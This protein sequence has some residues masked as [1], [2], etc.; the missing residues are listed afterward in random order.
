[1]QRFAT[2]YNRDFPDKRKQVFLLC[3]TTLLPHGHKDTPMAHLFIK[4]SP[5]FLLIV[6][7]FVATLAV[8]VNLH[9]TL[10]GD[11]EEASGQEMAS[12]A[13][14]YN[15]LLGEFQ[16]FQHQLDRC[17]FLPGRTEELGALRLRRTLLLQQLNIIHSA[18]TSGIAEINTGLN[19][20]GELEALSRDS[21]FITQGPLE[22]IRLVDLQ[23]LAEKT[24]NLQKRIS[25]LAIAASRLSTKAIS[26]SRITSSQLENSLLLLAGLQIILATVVLAAL[27]HASWNQSHSERVFHQR[28]NETEKT[29]SG[30]TVISMRH[31]HLLEDA[32]IRI[33]QPMSDL[34][35]LLFSSQ[36]TV[37]QD[38]QAQ[39]LFR[40]L[41]SA[42]E[43]S[44]EFALF[45]LGRLRA[46]HSETKLKEIIDQVI[47][48]CQEY[49]RE[50]Q[51]ELVFDPGEGLP[52][53]CE[54]DPDR[55]EKI[56]SRLIHH[57]IDR[58][59]KKRVNIH[60]YSDSMTGSGQGHLFIDITDS[61]PELPSPTNAQRKRRDKGKGET[62][63]QQED[64]SVPLAKGLA[65]LIGGNV[66]AI[67]R[68]GEG[69]IF[70]LD[71]PLRPKP[72]AG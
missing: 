4:R 18:R 16:R 65:R 47:D 27:F 66:T 17:I 6:T 49:A 1:M 20:L 2:I 46:K 12:A 37:Q 41:Q 61:G 3:H 56:L 32:M 26:Q 59:D 69:C 70:T 30:N 58:S 68:P 55:L 72:S 44:L 7:L 24:E 22:E 36:Q 52:N 5:I 45:N 25:P 13:W 31:A 40:K 28:L 67:S 19:L 53:V 21:A 51:V 35:T 62:S 63:V 8:L 42:I 9:M 48:E 54:T 29:L 60:I 33:R 14:Q 57:A 43:D 50:R 23:A 71:L 10:K 38:I 34:R 15:Q 11:R 39:K 64:I